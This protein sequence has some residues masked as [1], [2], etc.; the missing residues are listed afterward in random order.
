M[1][2]IWERRSDLKRDVKGKSSDMKEAEPANTDLRFYPV[3]CSLRI[4]ISKALLLL[5]G[6][7]VSGLRKFSIN[8]EPFI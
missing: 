4:Y 1:G 3:I 8:A 7:F 2:N 5:A 6:A